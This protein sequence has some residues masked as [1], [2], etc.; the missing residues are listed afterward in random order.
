MLLHVLLWSGVGQVNLTKHLTKYLTFRWKR[1]IWHL[2]SP[3][4]IK[5]KLPPLPVAQIVFAIHFIRVLR[6]SFPKEKF[7]LTHCQYFSFPPPFLP[8]FLF[9]LLLRNVFRFF[10]IKWK[11]VVPVIEMKWFLLHM[12]GYVMIKRLDLLCMMYWTANVNRTLLYY[13]CLS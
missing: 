12:R 7:P 8:I 10:V 9:I 5:K 13:T 6:F 1:V 3:Y 4:I 2:Y 11:F